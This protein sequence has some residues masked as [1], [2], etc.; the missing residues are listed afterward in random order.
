MY[1]VI[2]KRKIGL[3]H[4]KRASK[5]TDRLSVCV[6]ESLLYTK[7]NMHPIPHHAPQIN[8][9]SRI[10]TLTVCYM[11]NFRCSPHLNYI[12]IHLHP[13]SILSAFN[14]WCSSSL[15]A[16]KQCFI[17]IWILVHIANELWFVQL[18]GQCIVLLIYQSLLIM[19][20]IFSRKFN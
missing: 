19:N 3:V 4:V 11:F 1:C 6:E 9:F 20:K 12:F 2:S 18:Y 15:I 7:Y 13:F 10:I 17:F 14:V 16:E 5:H 8:Y